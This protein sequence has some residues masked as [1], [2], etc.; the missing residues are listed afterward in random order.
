MQIHMLHRFDR[1]EV[2]VVARGQADEIALL[3]AVIG[4]DDIF[5]EGGAVQ[6]VAIGLAAFAANDGIVV[7]AAGCVLEV[8]NRVAGCIATIDAIVG[9]IDRDRGCGRAASVD[10]ATPDGPE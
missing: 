6:R 4:D 5:C 3:V 2:G 7:S 1:G 9:Q 8:C 10:P